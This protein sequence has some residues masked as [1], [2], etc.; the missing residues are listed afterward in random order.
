MTEYQQRIRLNRA[1]RRHPKKYLA[2][3]EKWL[4]LGGWLL[5]GLLQRA[6]INPVNVDGAQV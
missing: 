6:G 4:G 1:A 3:T 2:N 5:A